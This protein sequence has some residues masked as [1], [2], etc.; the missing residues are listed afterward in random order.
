MVDPKEF[1][2]RDCATAVASFGDPAAND[3]ELCAVC[4]WLRSIADPA[5]RERVRSFLRT[6]P[7]ERR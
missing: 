2:C 7:W 6:P 5:E 1:I 3:Q 4:L